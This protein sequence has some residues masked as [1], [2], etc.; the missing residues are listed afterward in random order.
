MVI[1]RPLKILY[2]LDFTTALPGDLEETLKGEEWKDEAR[3]L[4]VLRGLGHEVKPL[5]L[6]DSLDPLLAE[7]RESRFDLVFNQCEGFGS[8]RDFEPHIVGLLEMLGVRYTGAGPASLTLCKDKGLT[9]QILSY[10]RVRVPRHVVSRRKRPVKRLV[11]F[12]FP[13]LTKPLNLEASEGIAQ[14]SFAE[15]EKEALERVDFIHQNLHTDAII[16]EY[17]EGREIYVA[18]M[19]N[20]KLKVFPP[21]ELFFEN[22]PSDEPRF[23]TFKAK[24]DDAYRKKW[25]IKTGYAKPL[26][27]ELDRKLVKMS[28]RIY[29]LFR[30]RGFARIDFRIRSDGEIVFLEAN[31]NPSIHKGEDFALSAEKAGLS[32][33]SLI[34]EILQLAMA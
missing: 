32:Y 26:G 22:M 5:A 2:L 33:E 23:A 14:L 11:N 25:G 17:I 30:V 6:Y 4:K 13:A 1:R 34:E 9:K 15:S 29:Q 27:L 10:H 12:A 31:P 28:K 8:T 19:G 3:I 16:E 7:L 18:V 21:R 24:W 20:E